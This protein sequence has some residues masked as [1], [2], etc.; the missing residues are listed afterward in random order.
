MMSSGFMFICISVLACCVCAMCVHVWGLP[1]KCCMFCVSEVCLVYVCGPT[2]TVLQR[3]SWCTYGAQG[4]PWLARWPRCHSTHWGNC[5]V[6]SP[7]VSLLS[8]FSNLLSI[9]SPS[10]PELLTRLLLH[11]SSLSSLKS[12]SL[13][14]PESI[15]TV[16]HYNILLTAFAFLSSLLCMKTRL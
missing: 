1:G 2:C 5:W 13:F 14:F 12:Q 16:F 3:V 7:R 15:A 8:T 4:E 6:F 11:I 10:E 9:Q